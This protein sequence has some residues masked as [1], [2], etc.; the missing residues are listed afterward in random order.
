MIKLIIEVT[1][2]LRD[3]NGNCYHIAKITN[4]RNSKS[5]TT[6]TPSTS[7]VEGI[8]NRAGYTW[9]ETYTAQK[10][11]SI[12]DFNRIKKYSDVEYLNA[13]RWEKSWKKALNSIGLKPRNKTEA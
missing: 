4:T 12:R 13:C 3:S 6:D 5:F 11:E 7:N 8:L 10:W 1:S 2:S 9:K